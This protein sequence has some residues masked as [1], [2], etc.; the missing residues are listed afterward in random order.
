ME[1]KINV[2]QIQKAQKIT[3]IIN[4]II[5]YTFLCFMAIIVLI[6]FYWMINTAFKSSNEVL[7]FPPTLFPNTIVWENFTHVLTTSSFAR[8]LGNTVFV[9]VIS[10][11]CTIITTTLGA[12]AFSRLAFKGQNLLFSI[13]LA[14]MMI[15]G[16]MFVITNY[17]TVSNFGWLNSYQV[18]IVPFV[19]SIFYIFLLR[20]SF[21][22][23]PNE[24]YYAAKVDGT[25]DFKYLIKVMIPIAKPTIITIIIL[26]LMGA[27]NSYIWPNLVNEAE[28]KLIS[29]W[30]RDSFTDTLNGI[31]QVNYQMMSS[32]IVTMPLFLV[33]I[34]CRKFI[35]QGVSRSGIKG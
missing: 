30:M 33:F 27:W 4:K 13:L 25:G 19:V 12:F 2:E 23:I 21:K 24:L 35:M 8:Y 26:D 9:G 28:Y 29:N 11:I 17:I 22:Q 18:L 32:F 31:S 1:N 3:S 6:P 14:T 20:Q 15:P 5:V 7:Q 10:T 16:E 34:F